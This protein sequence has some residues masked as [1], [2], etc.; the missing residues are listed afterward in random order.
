MAGLGLLLPGLGSH[1]A[2]LASAATPSI[3]L[4]LRS[5]A[6]IGPAVIAST[7]S[8]TEPLL[9][10][11]GSPILP[12]SSRVSSRPTPPTTAFAL[13]DQARPHVRLI[14]DSVLSPSIA[15]QVNSQN[16]IVFVL[17]IS[18][19]MYEPYAGSTRL[20]LAR[21][22]LSQRIRDLQDG[23]PFAVTVYGER[24]LRSGPLVP[25]N[26]ATREAAIQYL[27]QEYDC[28]GGTNLPAGLALAEEL[29]MG[30]VLLVTDGDFNMTAAELLP[31]TRKILGGEGQTPALT[32][33]GI[34]PR[35]HTDA[36]R[37]LDE[38]VEQQGGTYQSMQE[39]NLTAS[40]TPAKSDVATP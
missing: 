11:N 18:G 36:G 35:D 4:H 7:S 34:G 23:T 39:G 10:Q 9:K 31:K 6:T 29:K 28:G 12:A 22:L 13:R 30:S 3:I 27:N 20:T 33:V 15:P 38:L 16:G 5:E 24:A 32:V 17:D 14:S 21:Q 26:K 25:A 40:L 37:L 2:S 1:Q 19:S 8:P